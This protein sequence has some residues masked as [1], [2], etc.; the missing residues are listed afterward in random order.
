MLYLTNVTKVYK[1]ETESLNDVSLTVSPGEFVAI[2]GH[3]GSGKTT[4]MKL[5]LAEEI[6]TSGTIFY[7]SQDIHSL[8]RKDLLILRRRIGTIFQDFRLIKNKTVFENVAFAMEVGEHSDE[9]ILEYV[10]HILELVSLQDKMYAFPETLSGGEKQRL[11]IARAII[12]QP[13]LL[14]ADEPT[15]SLDPESAHSVMQ[16][17]RKLSDLGTTVLMTTHTPD[18][19]HKYAR[20]FIELEHGRIVKD[21]KHHTNS[22][23]H[24]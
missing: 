5:I 22:K 20:R 24:I 19:A 18:L 4:I 10:P 17:L 15:S 11:A 2:M 23:M 12:N 16:V 3:S 7:E 8:S 6:P 9:D 13:E 14:L 21:D 1:D